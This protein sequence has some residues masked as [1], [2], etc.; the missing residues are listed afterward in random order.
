MK[1][2]K[3][4][5][6]LKSVRQHLGRRKLHSPDLFKVYF[7]AFVSRVEFDFEFKAYWKYGHT[8]I[9]LNLS[10]SISA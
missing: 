4:S 6:Y 9:I 1:I 3:Y 7:A 8:I 2:R 10:G 5:D